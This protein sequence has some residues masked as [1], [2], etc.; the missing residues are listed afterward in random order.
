M[1]VCVAKSISSGI[2]ESLNGYTNLEVR[3]RNRVKQQQKKSDVRTALH[4]NKNSSH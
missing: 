2:I 3:N 1:S 4:V